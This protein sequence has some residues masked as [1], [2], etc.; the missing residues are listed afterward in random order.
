MKWKEAG[1]VLF[2]ALLLVAVLISITS[3]I[4][5]AEKKRTPEG[6]PLVGPIV[7]KAPSALTFEVY[8]GPRKVREGLWQVRIV[9]HKDGKRFS[10]FVVSPAHA[11]KITIGS[12]VDIARVLYGVRY[13]QTIIP[14]VRFL[15]VVEFVPSGSK[16]I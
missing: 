6:A 15:T 12:R 13:Q 3:S 9:R 8:Q 11:R 2:G 10:A 14:I 7:E 4:G 5:A 16:K 1:V